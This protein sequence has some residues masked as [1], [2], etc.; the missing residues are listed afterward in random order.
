ME[1]KKEYRN[2]EQKSLQR[3]L[4]KRSILKHRVFFQKLYHNIIIVIGEIYQALFNI[5]DLIP[6]LI[7]RQ[8]YIKNIQRLSSY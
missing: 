7:L 6:D 1:Q 5:Q 8:K 4:I 3:E 2:I